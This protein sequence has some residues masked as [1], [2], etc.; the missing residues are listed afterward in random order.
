MRSSAIGVL[1]AV[2]VVLG[3]VNMSAQ[4]TPDSV[5]AHVAGE[6]RRRP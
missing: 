4:S 6:G 3:G 5:Q 2:I 1:A